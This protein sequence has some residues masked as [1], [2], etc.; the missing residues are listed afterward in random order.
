MSTIKIIVIPCD[1]ERP[2]EVRE[3]EQG[4]LSAMQQIVGK[5]VEVLDIEN[6][7]ASIWLN[8]EGKWTGLEPNGRAT[9]LLWV[10]Q[11]D[12]RER[13]Y[14]VG[15]CFITGQPN[16]EGD[17]TSAPDQ[18]IDLVT[19]PGQYKVQVQTLSDDSWSG[20]GKI[21]DHWLEAYVWGLGLASR[22]ALVSEIRVITT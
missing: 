3:I 4:D 9:C 20:N 19:K 13:D 7:S 2:I 15:N 18:L 5:Y 6:P 10:H 21:F 14:L 8:E 1:E 22:W 12:Y 17:T 11:S 16:D